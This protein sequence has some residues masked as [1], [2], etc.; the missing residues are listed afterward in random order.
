MKKISTTNK[1]SIKQ[2]VVLCTAQRPMASFSA[3]VLQDPSGRSNSGGVDCLRLPM[4]VARGLHLP[5]PERRPSYAPVHRVRLTLPTPGPRGLR[6]AE[7]LLHGRHVRFK[8]VCEKGTTG[9]AT[10]CGS[11]TFIVVYIFLVQGAN[12]TFFCLPRRQ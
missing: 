12:I 8:G 4:A 5:C 10:R 6:T 9:T 3:G 1:V 7:D 2:V 11:A